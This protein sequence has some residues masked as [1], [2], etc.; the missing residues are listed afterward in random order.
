MDYRAIRLFYRIFGTIG[1]RFFF[2]KQCFAQS[3]LIIS[4]SPGITNSCVQTRFK[5]RLISFEHLPFSFYQKY[6]RTQ[7]AIRDSFPKLK[8]VVVLTKHEKEVYLSLGCHVTVIPNAFSSA[9]EVVSTL[10]NKI[11]LSVG[12]F[13]QQKRRDLLIAAWSIVNKR[14]PDWKLVIVGDGE[15]AAD[16]V[17]QIISLNLVDSIEIVPPTTEI[18]KHY[19]AA[20]IFVLS[21][22]YESFSLVLLEAKLTGVPC[23]SFDVVSGPNEVVQAGVDGFLIPCPDVNAMADKIV[24]LIEDTCLRKKFGTAAMTDAKA[25]FNPKH[26]Y[27][28]WDNLLAE[29]Y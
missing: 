7:K 2:Q 27:S 18:Q 1:L 16:A 25:R 14:H 11:V 9:P 12:H 10:D 29:Y 19:S 28:L 22:E 6:P 26:I 24:L 17:N 8:S 20:S 4:F 15:Q 3:Q 23:V 5:K 13:N 21:S